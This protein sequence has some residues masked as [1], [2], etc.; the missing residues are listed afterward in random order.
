[1]ESFR[2]SIQK[3]PAPDLLLLAGDLVL[4]N[5]YSQL[6]KLMSVIRES[7]DGQVVA[8][9]GNEEY[10]Q[11]RA[12]YRR[13]EDILWL[14]DGAKLLEIK[15]VKL[16]VVGSKGS[17][18]RPTFWQSTHMRGIGQ[19]YR[20]RVTKIDSL[21]EELRA[22]IRIVLT[23]YAPTYLSLEGENERLWPEA[24]CRRFEQVI[25]KRHP[26]AWIHGHAHHGVKK[27]VIVGS[28]PIFN[29][30]LPARGEVTTIELPRKVGLRRF[31]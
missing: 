15:G 2:N 25:L 8:C 19:I 14:N 11:S 18:D 20:E 3:I 13:F 10:E 23:H 21:L 27:E 12:E 24:G 1:L 26:D 4:K 29:V 5:D 7:Y 30:A 28:T 9:F 17:L 22:D 6:P 16:G 31:I